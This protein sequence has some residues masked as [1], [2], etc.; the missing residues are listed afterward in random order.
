MPWPRSATARPGRG[1]PPD[2]TRASSIARRYAEAYFA[3]AREAGDVAGWRAELGGVALA[4][5]RAEVAR[6]LENPKLSMANRL[7]LG[8]DLL[9]GA[10]VPARNLARLLIE[11]RRVGI[12]GEILA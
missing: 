10:G 1:G 3:L 7:K 2:V 6:A 9:D 8:L 4:F 5:A 11:R 12:A